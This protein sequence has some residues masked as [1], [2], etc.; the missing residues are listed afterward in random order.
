M[1]EKMRLVELGAN[2]YHLG[3]EVE[4]AREKLKWFSEHGEP[5]DSVELKKAIERFNALCE[6]WNKTEEEYL[7]EKALYY[8]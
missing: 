8:M 4:T 5:S 7:K 2:L 6:A 1:K 3:H